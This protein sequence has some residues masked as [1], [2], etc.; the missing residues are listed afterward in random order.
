MKGNP[1]GGCAAWR[2]DVWSGSPGRSRSRTC[3]ACKTDRMHGRDRQPRP[4]DP[5]SCG[6]CRSEHSYRGGPRLEPTGLGRQVRRVRWGRGTPPVNREADA[7][8]VARRLA[9]GQRTRG[10]LR[11]SWCLQIPRTI[12][13]SCFG[14]SFRETGITAV[15]PAENGVAARLR[16]SRDT[17][18]GKSWPIETFFHK[19]VCCETVC[20]RSS[21]R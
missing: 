14:G 13:N 11:P 18:T 8:G 21:S 16:S 20:G 19:V 12:S 9:P 1:E 3:R 10:A 6:F 4:T 15:A 7:R 17:R 2:S 5:V